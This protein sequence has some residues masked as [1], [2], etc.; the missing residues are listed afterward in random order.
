LYNESFSKIPRNNKRRQ[1]KH[2]MRSCFALI[3][4]LA[5]MSESI[6]KTN[7]LSKADTIEKRHSFVRTFHGIQCNVKI[8]Y[9]HVPHLGCGEKFTQNLIKLL[10]FPNTHVPMAPVYKLLSQKSCQQFPDDLSR[11]PPH[12]L[13][14]KAANPPPFVQPRIPST[15]NAGKVVFCIGIKNL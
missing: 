11:K 10:F 3:P 5:K 4:E 1:K 13:A 2:T 14:K 7:P 15:R 8:D 6:S 9:H 12:Q